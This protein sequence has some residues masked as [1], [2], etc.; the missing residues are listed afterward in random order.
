MLILGLPRWLNGTDITCQAR[1][2]GLIPRSGI[3]SGEGQPSRILAWRI[4]LEKPG[5]LQSMGSQSVRH[6]QVTKHACVAYSQRKILSFS[7]YYYL[8]FFLI[9]YSERWHPAPT[10]AQLMFLKI[11]LVFSEESKIC[12]YLRSFCGTFTNLKTV[13]NGKCIIF[14]I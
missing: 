10:V 11:C 13:H 9:L 8:I 6:N 1:D 5:G 14:T 12:C 2:A 4:P 7:G 3:S